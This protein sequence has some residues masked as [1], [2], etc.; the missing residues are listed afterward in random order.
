M[1]YPLSSGGLLLLPIILPLGTALLSFGCKRRPQVPVLFGSV[2]TLLAILALARQYLAHGL[3]S[4]EIGGWSPVLGISL[5]ADGLSLLMLILTG[6]VGVCVSFYAK[7]YFS[8]SNN[9]QNNKN[10]GSQT[11]FWP[12]WMML[13]AGLNCLYLSGDLFNIYVTLELVGL[14]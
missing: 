2:F 9:G 13:W 3:Q 10:S 6:V 12:L 4:H 11:S 7:G 1:S 8:N 5:R 14:A